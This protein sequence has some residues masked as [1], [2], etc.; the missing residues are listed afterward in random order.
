[1]KTV[2]VRSQKEYNALPDKAAVKINVVGFVLEVMD[3]R[4]ILVGNSHAE[5]W[6]SSH[7]ELWGNSRATV[8]SA[9]EI[10]A[11]DNSSVLFYKKPKIMRLLNNATAKAFITPV[12]NKEHLIVCERPIDGDDK[13]IVLYKSVNPETDCDFYTGKYKYEIGKLSS[14]RILTPT[15]ILCVVRAFICV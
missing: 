3:E 14:V 4:V 8:V 6:G 9:D 12:Y 7:A 15:P 5:L 10:V 11:C 2:A 13:T 1:M